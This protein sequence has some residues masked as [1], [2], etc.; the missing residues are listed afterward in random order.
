MYTVIFAE[1]R[2]VNKG[3]TITITHDLQFSKFWSRLHY[4]LILRFVG[5]INACKTYAYLLWILRDFSLPS[6]WKSSFN[7]HIVKHSWVYMMGVCYFCNSI[8]KYDS[9]ISAWCSS[10]HMY[11]LKSISANVAMC[12][13]YMSTP[14]TIP[15]VNMI[16]WFYYDGSFAWMF[17]ISLQHQNHKTTF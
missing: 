5:H 1:Q 10:A 16:L 14:H 6:W 2:E 7:L 13:T 17:L 3:R 9:M 11:I 12:S 4:I 8:Y 15:F